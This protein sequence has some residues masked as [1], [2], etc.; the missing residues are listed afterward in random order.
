MARLAPR[1]R[2]R[3]ERQL[4]DVNGKLQIRR[5]EDRLAGARTVSVPTSLLEMLESAHVGVLWSVMSRAPWAS[6]ARHDPG[7]RQQQHDAHPAQQRQ[8]GLLHR[9][10]SDVSDHVASPA[11]ESARAE[12][13]CTRPGRS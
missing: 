9:H 13:S 5:A 6:D 12:R 11:F 3:V 8:Q 4:I 2:T 10:T 7:A 1:P